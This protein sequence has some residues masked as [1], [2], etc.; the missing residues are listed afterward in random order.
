MKEVKNIK[1]E[2]KTPDNFGH[3]IRNPLAIM[4]LNLDLIKGSDE[5]KNLP[6][7]QKLVKTMDKEVGRI[8]KTLSNFKY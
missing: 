6:K 4:K 7:V 3:D 5:Y 8:L 1:N 2:P